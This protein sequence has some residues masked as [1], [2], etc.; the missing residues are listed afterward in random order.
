LTIT[1]AANGLSFIALAC[2][3]GVDAK[4]SVSFSGGSLYHQ[5]H[6]QNHHQSSSGSSSSTFSNS[7]LFGVG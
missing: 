7:S 6:H 1:S 2:N 5:N 3:N 4:L